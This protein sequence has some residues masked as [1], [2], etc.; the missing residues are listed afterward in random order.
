MKTFNLFIKKYNIYLLLA[1]IILLQ[2]V[3][4]TVLPII[5][6]D[7]IQMNYGVTALPAALKE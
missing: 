6:K 2:T 4:L 1:C 7:I 5:R 3:C